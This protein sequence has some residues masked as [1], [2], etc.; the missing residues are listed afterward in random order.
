MRLSI[1]LTFVIAAMTAGDLPFKVK[2]P[3]ELYTL[4]CGRLDFPDMTPFSDTGEYAGETGTMAVPCY[5]IHHDKEWMLWDAG[6]GDRLASLPNG[7]VKLG[8]TY[9]VTRTLSAQLAKLGLK[10]DDV[11]YVALSHLHSDHTGNINLFPNAT[12]LISAKELAW[13]RQIPTPAGV[14]PSLI[15]PLAHDALKLSDEYVD[16]FGDGSVELL[17]APGHTPG[18]RMLFISLARSGSVLISGDLYHLR[19]DYEKG[20]IP[21]QNVSRSDTLA[22]FQR[23][24]RIVSNT[25]ARVV[26]QHSPGDFAAMPQFPR[27]LN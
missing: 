7:E 18:H 23:F 20:L 22:S 12:F 3:V 9:T 24:A 19:R 11:R 14:E 1:A 15:A 25:H 26:I 6:L 8:A 4:N 10:P 13:T 16:V 2:A 17:K 27:Y 21:A 5:L